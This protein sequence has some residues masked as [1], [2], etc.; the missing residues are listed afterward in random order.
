MPNTL[1]MPNV[2]KILI[3]VISLLFGLMLVACDNSMDP[4][5]PYDENTPPSKQAKAS[6]SGSVKLEGQAAGRQDAV[7]ITLTSAAAE[8]DTGGDQITVTSDSDGLFAFTQSIMPGRVSLSFSL[9]NY[10]EGTYGPIDVNPGESINDVLV[11]MLLRRS[12]VAGSVKLEG[13]DENGQKIVDFSGATIVL[14]SSDKKS[15]AMRLISDEDSQEEGEDESEA[16]E[17][18]LNKTYTAGS[19][20]DGSYYLDGIP[21]GEYEVILGKEGFSTYFGEAVVESET[22]S[23]PEVI[24]V[25]SLGALAIEEGAEYVN[26][27]EVS[28]NFRASGLIKKWWLSEDPNFEDE[29][30]VSGETPEG[31]EADFIE[32][33]FILSGSDGLKIVFGKYE[34]LEGVASELASDGITLDTTPPQN[35]AVS[36]NAGAEYLID[37]VAALSLQASDKYSDVVSMRIS[38]DGALD[39]ETAVDYALNQTVTLNAPETGDGVELS[40][41][42][43]FI[44]GAGNES[45]AVSDS[46]LFDNVAPQTGDSA[47]SINGGAV[48]TAE[49]AVTLNF[50]VSGAS[51]MKISNDSGL[52]DGEWQPYAPLLSGWTLASADVEEDKNVYAVFR[53]RAGN[54]T[55]IVSDSITLKTSGFIAG[56][57]SIVPSDTSE[58]Y[59]DLNF[60]LDTQLLGSGVGLIDLNTADGS[61][62]ISDIKYGTYAYLRIV[63]PDFTSATSSVV[64]INPGE[65]SDVGTL[66]LSNTVGSIT[67]QVELEQGTTDGMAFRLGNNLLADVSID[68][69]GNFNIENVGVGSYPYLAVTKEG[70]DEARSDFFEVQPGKEYDVGTLSL[71]LSRGAVEGYAKLMSESDHAGILVRFEGSSYTTVTDSSGYFYKDGV[72][73]ASYELSFSKD[74]FISRSVDVDVNP[75]ELSSISSSDL[76]LWLSEQVGDFDIDG[77]AAYTNQ[78]FVDLELKYADAVRIRV[79]ENDL[80]PE[81]EEPPFELISDLIASGVMSIEADQITMHYQYNFMEDDGLRAVIDGRKIINV[82]FMVE[83]ELGVET[84][85]DVLSASIILDTL[86][87]QLYEDPAPLVINSGNDYTNSPLASLQ[88]NVYD[89]NGIEL[90]Y[91]SDDNEN[92]LPSTYLPSLSHILAMPDEDGLK[93][94]YA[95]FVDPAG[96]ETEVV[97]D[98]ITLD[99]EKPVFVN[100]EIASDYVAQNGDKYTNTP[101]VQLNMEATGASRMMLSNENSFEGAVWE[102]YGVGKVWS[103]P[104][105]NG[106]HSVYIKFSDEAGNIVGDEGEYSDTVIL[107]MNAPQAPQ[108]TL[109]GTHIV[110]QSTNDYANDTAISL[111]FSNIPADVMAQV[112]TSVSFNNEAIELGGSLLSFNL[113]EEDG[114]QVVYARYIDM[115]GNTSLPAQRAVVLD[116]VHPYD[117]QVSVL[118]GSPSNTRNVNLMLSVEGANQMLIT[119]GLTCPSSGTWVAYASLKQ[120]QSSS[121]DD[122]KTFSVKFRDEAHNE[123]T[124]EKASFDLDETDP[125]VDSFTIEEAAVNGF[126]NNRSVTLAIS[127]SD[128]GG[129]ASMRLTNEAAFGGEEEGWEPYQ[130]SKSWTLSSGSDTKT[131]RLQV[132]DNADN[133]NLIYGAASITLDSQAPTG[134]AAAITDVDGYVQNASVQIQISATDNLTDDED[135]RYYLSNT[136]NFPALSEYLDWPE[137]RRG[138]FYRSWDLSDSDGMKTVYLRVVDLAGNIS[139]NNDS[140]ILDSEGPSG[141]TAYIQE[142]KYLDDPNVHLIALASGATQ[143][144]I[145]GNVMD[146]VYTGEWVSFQTSTPIE[147][148]PDTCEEGICSIEVTFRDNADWSDGPVTLSVLL[149]TDVPEGSIS[150]NSGNDYTNSTAVTITLNVSDNSILSSMRL[151]NTGVFT[152]EWEPFVETRGWVLP[153]LDTEHT[154]YVQVKDI[155][156][157]DYTFEDSITLDRSAP[158]SVQISFPWG[159]HPNLHKYG[160]IILASGL[161]IEVGVQGEDDSTPAEDLLFYLSNDSTFDEDELLDFEARDLQDGSFDWLLDDGDG[162]KVIYLRVMDLA[163]NAKDVSTS[164]VLDTEA[165][166]GSLTILGDDPTSYSTVYLRFNASADTKYYKLANNVEPDCDSPTGYLE[167]PTNSIISNWD[168][169]VS[170]ENTVTVYACIADRATNTTLLEDEVHV[171]KVHPT[172]TVTIAGNDPTNNATVTLNITASS[173]VEQMSIVNGTSLNCGTAV[174][175]AFSTTRTW[176]LESQTGNRTVTVCVK[177]SAENVNETEI[178]DNVYLDLIAPDATVQIGTGVSTIN[179]QTV[180]LNFNYAS[181]LRDRV[182]GDNDI[183]QLKVENGTNINCKDNTGWQNRVDYINNWVLNSPSGTT[184]NFGEAT[185]YVSACFKDAAGN[186]SNHTTSVFLDTLPPSGTISLRGSAYV[187][188]IV[189]PGIVDITYADDA[190]KMY[191]LVED[192]NAP[193]DCDSIADTSYDDVDDTASVTFI[194]NSLIEDGIYNWIFLCLKDEAGNYSSKTMSSICRVDTNT[195]NEGLVNISGDDPT[196]NPYVEL[197]FSNVPT[198]VTEVAIKNGLS[199]NCSTVTYQGYVSAVSWSLEAKEGLQSVSVCFKDHAGNTN[200][201]AIKDQV[202][203]DITPPSIPAPQSPANNGYS[204]T[205]DTV[206][207]WTAVYDDDETEVDEYELRVYSGADLSSGSSYY[208]STNTKTLPLTEGE[209]YRWHV[210][211]ADSVGNWSN[212]STVYVFTVDSLPPTLGSPAIRIN[213]G[214]NYTRYTT[215]EVAFIVSDAAYM[216]VACDGTMDSDVAWVTFQTPYNCVM[217]DVDETKTIVVQFKDLAGNVKSTTNGTTPIT[218][219]IMLDRTPPGPPVIATVGRVVNEDSVTVQTSGSCSDVSSGCAGIQLKG[220][221]LYSDWTLAVAS[222]SYPIT[223][224]SNRTNIISM[225]YIDNAGNTSSEEFV[226]FRQDSIA[227]EDPGSVKAIPGSRS[228]RISWQDSVFDIGEMSDLG[229]YKIY[230]HY[231]DVATLA[232]MTGTFADQGDSPIDVGMVNSFTLTGLTNDV[233]VYIAITAYDLT[234]VPA[235][236]ESSGDS[237]RV[238]GVPMELPIIRAGSA[239]SGSR[240]VMSIDDMIQRKGWLY[241]VSAETGIQI[242]R[243]RDVIAADEETIEPVGELD[244]T[245]THRTRME[246]FGNYLYLFDSEVRYDGL[247]DDAIASNKGVTVVDVS[248][249]AAPVFADAANPIRLKQNVS[250]SDD[251]Y[252]Q[253]FKSGQFSYSASGENSHYAYAIAKVDEVQPSSLPVPPETPVDEWLFIRVDMSDPANPVVNDWNT[254]AIL[255]END[256]CSDHWAQGKSRVG[257]MDITTVSAHVGLF[258]ANST[259]HKNRYYK[260]NIEHPSVLPSISVGQPDVDLLGVTRSLTSS[261]GYEFIANQNGILITDESGA[262]QKSFQVGTD[263][264]RDL[265][266]SPGYAFIGY[267]ANTDRKT[268]RAVRISNSSGQ[269]KEEGSYRIS[270]SDYFSGTALTALEIDGNYLFAS[271][272]GTGIGGIVAY[273]TGDPNRLNWKSQ[274]SVTSQYGVKAFQPHKD[275]VYAAS[276]EKFVIFRVWDIDAPEKILET[277]LSGNFQAQYV[278]TMLT[279]GADYVFVG[280]RYATGTDGKFNFIDAHK[281]RMISYTGVTAG[282]GIKTGIT[283]GDTL[284]LVHPTTTCIKT[285]DLR[286]LLALSNPTALV[287]YGSFECSG[288]DMNSEHLFVSRWYAPAS[289]AYT[290]E[291]YTDDPQVSISL[292]SARYATGMS[293]CGLIRVNADDALVTYSSSS[294][295]PTAEILNGNTLTAYGAAFN[296]SSGGFSTVQWAG[297]YVYLSDGSI[298]NVANTASPE[299]YNM[300]GSSSVNEILVSGP[301]LFLNEGAITSFV[302]EQ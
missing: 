292:P 11:K 194:G 126:T 67:G 246:L 220:G 135:L 297:S 210:R 278:T 41:L 225:R 169:G 143:M 150:I 168:L 30:T 46:I 270:S 28:V 78:L 92:W 219:T 211:A 59:G 184:G 189:S 35:T 214:A 43:S 238:M 129:I 237:S 44:D 131:V 23:M 152:S 109:A 224:N 290:Y 103:I 102:Q 154:V 302:M 29:S 64:I 218:D 141:S 19:D 236:N 111:Q 49:A 93:T 273:N 80:D 232:E 20:S 250:T 226:V 139:E 52:G 53:D 69:E 90:V 294:S 132:K 201:I 248:D 241:T 130:E 272:K 133:V 242:Y 127:A 106:S 227:P 82:Q 158:T 26:A 115:A 86:E 296:E 81:A 176:N 123:S 282:L 91:V 48:F 271:Y 166:A 191:V 163:G 10:E 128:D 13:L 207:G 231:K 230:Y 186:I 105:L 100:F 266:I 162:L 209:T 83:E 288:I 204:R 98:D 192:S 293:G 200:S 203:L 175:E 264:A 180:K 18:T 84:P 114:V 62:T 258:C 136:P 71:M 255:L 5:N 57:V 160:N 108:F 155:A 68:G 217:S 268:I 32:E 138:S 208:V 55:S 22:L 38:L 120:V 249:P 42:V 279:F 301:L 295:G 66:T 118:E 8:G 298:W 27:S 275:L 182:I 119:E 277:T 94:V 15:K 110:H 144:F 157:N 145:T 36:I 299:L 167:F 9:M 24:L 6:L 4:T 77:G 72:V 17:E 142:G 193:P 96:N 188:N 21:Y 125:E 25:S 61:F 88:F 267:D 256:E 263:A 39:D 3:L 137:G 34:T 289:R 276:Y 40:A 260:I 153:A 285:Y 178:K 85:S 198:D 112:D 171:D 254:D 233:P 173:D 75:D 37:P 33:T 97:N 243:A 259:S 257:D 1:N 187:N 148:D 239:I 244:Q 2:S 216:R 134:V 140:V 165:P 101:S 222:G 269:F 274:L 185:V 196:N 262:L 151:S 223:L 73:A 229:G 199:I 79:S 99:T 197:T 122:T 14:R 161:D 146:T 215:V 240:A 265:E 87:P 149:D 65:S 283:Y 280:F 156:G 104:M 286:N 147:L 284:L 51:E 107:D 95:Y 164:L 253:A 70:F 124:C 89:E 177:D 228:L 205:L 117:P 47:L 195:P 206:F 74:G 60:Y 54:T 261:H 31:T 7:T 213:G 247:I 121:G 113:D 174:Y 76:P 221:S 172:G 291:L 245:E 50:D 287:Q 159:V 183:K 281:E 202:Y 252:F 179:T 56:V 300:V 58:P 234:E 235:P 170:T 181:D 116:T 190:E 45:E 251:L 212:F 16:E 63:K 12:S